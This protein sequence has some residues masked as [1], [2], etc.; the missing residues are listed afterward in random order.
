M[1]EGAFQG[2]VVGQGVFF[3]GGGLEEP[4]GDRVG[5]DALAV[6]VEVRDDPV[7]QHGVGDAPDVLIGEGGG[8]KSLYRWF[9]R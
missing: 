1:L 3:V 2:G 8:D 5:S 9:L 7:A 6:G 4:V